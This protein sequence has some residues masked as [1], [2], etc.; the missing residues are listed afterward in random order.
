MPG[1]LWRLDNTFYAGHIV[2]PVHIRYN[3]KAGRK[4]SGTVLLRIVRIRH[5]N[6]C[7]LNNASGNWVCR[8]RF[9]PFGKLSGMHIGSGLCRVHIY[10]Y[11]QHV[12]ALRVKQLKDFSPALPQ[13]V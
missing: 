8:R 10:H 9:E 3:N 13:F 12:H 11:Q 2:I 5:C 4:V 7:K 6:N 1:E